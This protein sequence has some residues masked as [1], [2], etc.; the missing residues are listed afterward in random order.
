MSVITSPLGDAERKT[1]GDAL[2]G[3][4]I[5][6]IDLS[7]TAKQYHWNL[8]GP[9]FRSIHLQLD[10]VVASARTHADTVAERA[11]A[12][13]VSPDGRAQTV[14]AGAAAPS[15]PAWVADTAVVDGVVRLL[16]DIGGRLRGHIDAVA[17]AD[18]VSQDILIAVARDLEKQAWMFEAQAAH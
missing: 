18:P 6:L 9:R 7:L 12:I 11:A 16:R 1:T 17:E 10:E 2:Q 5:D 13:G 4:L 8:V 15:E 3:T 14:A